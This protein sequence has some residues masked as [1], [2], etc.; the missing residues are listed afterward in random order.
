VCCNQNFRCKT[1]PL[2]YSSFYLTFPAFI[3]SLVLNWPFFN[4]NTGSFFTIWATREGVLT[5]P[6]CIPVLSHLRHFQ[7]FPPYGLEPTRFVCPWDCP[8]KTTGKG[9]PALLQGIFPIQ[10]SNPCLL[11]LLHWQMGSLPLLPPGKPFSMMVFVQ[12][13]LCLTLRPHGLQHT[14]LPVYHQLPEFTQTLST[15]SVMPSNHLILCHPLLFL[16]SILPSIKVFS[17]ESALNIRWPKYW[18]FSMIDDIKYFFG[19]FKKWVYCK[20]KNAYICGN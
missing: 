13:H 7:H 8:G 11:R 12:T 4:L 5:S 9:C 2:C 16:P 6:W 10:G 17:N 3:F 20:Q 15:E 19:Q 14:G 1:I 18:S